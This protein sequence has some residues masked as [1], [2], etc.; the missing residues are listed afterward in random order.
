MTLA[1][2]WRLVNCAD[3]LNSAQKDI[4]TSTMFKQVKTKKAPFR[5]FE[6]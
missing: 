2:N 6:R 4:K 5:R 3:K 1:A